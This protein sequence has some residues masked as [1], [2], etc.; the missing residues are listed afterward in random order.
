MSR[1][2]SDKEIER[3][4]EEL[5]KLPIGS[6]SRKTIAGKVRYYRQWVED[7]R[8]RSEYLKESEVDGV[9]RLIERRRELAKM[10]RPYGAGAR[11]YVRV[12]AA[13][14]TGR[15][16]GDWADFVS[17][18]DARDVFPDIMKFLRWPSESKV[19]IVF[20]LRRT[21]KTTMLQQA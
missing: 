16:L 19:L 12:D 2:L 3:Y 11:P 1:G 4:R 8:T 6:I 18:W 20:G 5:A 13:V 17:G 10:L 15:E 9:R 14:K 21:G 7:G